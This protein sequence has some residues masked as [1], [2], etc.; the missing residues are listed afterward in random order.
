[1][2][3]FTAVMLIILISATAFIGYSVGQEMGQ[4]QGYRK[5]MSHRRQFDSS[6]R[7]EYL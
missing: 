7:E 3:A 1:M 2:V 6:L 4:E 5:A